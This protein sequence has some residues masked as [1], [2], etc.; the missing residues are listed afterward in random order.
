MQPAAL[1]L[2]VRIGPT[3]LAPAAAVKDGKL[4]M[5]LGRVSVAVPVRA[6]AGAELQ[7]AFRAVLPE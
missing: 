7:K 6:A 4:T 5:T 1:G 3:E 2:A